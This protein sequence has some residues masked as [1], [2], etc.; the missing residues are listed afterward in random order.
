MLR[1]RH[2]EALDKFWQ[3]H[4]GY[5]IGCL[6]ELEAQNLCRQQSL[7]AIQD[8]LAQAAVEARGR[9]LEVAVEPD[10]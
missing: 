1:E 2:G 9:G 8:F 4:F 6:T 5:G 7:V 10:E 3:A